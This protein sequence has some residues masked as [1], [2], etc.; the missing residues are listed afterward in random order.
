MIEDN[1]ETN[2]VIQDPQTGKVIRKKRMYIDP[3][4]VN[5]GD[6]VYLRK[7]RDTH[8]R[9]PARVTQKGSRSL[10]CVI[11]QKTHTIKNDGTLMSKPDTFVAVEE[12]DTITPNRQ[13]E[14]YQGGEEESKGDQSQTAEEDLAQL[15]TE[16]AKQEETHRSQ[17]RLKA[18][19]WYEFKSNDGNGRP[20][21]STKAR[22]TNQSR[23][24]ANASASQL[25]D[26]QLV[27]QRGAEATLQ[28]SQS[29]KQ[30][31]NTDLLHGTSNTQSSTPSL[32]AIRDGERRAPIEAEN[33]SAMVNDLNHGKVKNALCNNVPKLKKVSRMEKDDTYGAIKKHQT[34]PTSPKSKKPQ[35]TPH[36]KR[37]ANSTNFAVLALP[38]QCNVCEKEIPDKD[39]LQHCQSDHNL[40]A[41]GLPMQC[42]ICERRS[43]PPLAAN[44]PVRLSWGLLCCSVVP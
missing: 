20:V 1:P 39:F 9:G 5:I 26:T 43:Q 35:D 30:L 21:Q 28:V 44:L 42:T 11:R 23:H 29:H 14:G 17:R 19:L 4:E 31:T 15:K 8:W 37:P 27:L 34:E 22:D 25:Y 38:V 10:Q 40:D 16:L 6:R 13:T 24:A 32:E 18:E 3:T 36:K 2:R 41:L 33:S 7:L 12:E